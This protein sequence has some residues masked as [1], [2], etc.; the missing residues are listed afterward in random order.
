[1]AKK[2]NFD[3]ELAK[4]MAGKQEKTGKDEFTEEMH[5]TF[6]LSEEDEKRAAVFAYLQMLTTEPNKATEEEMAAYG[7]T[8]EDIR[9]YRPD[10]LNP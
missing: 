10:F 2:F 3:E 9:K 5:N 4:A 6:S 7:I 1:M 8:A